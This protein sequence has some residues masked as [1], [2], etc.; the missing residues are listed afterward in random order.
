MHD[1]EWIFRCNHVP[2]SIIR[3]TRPGDETGCRM[4]SGHD[5]P[6]LV[7]AGNPS[8]IVSAGQYSKFFFFQTSDD[9]DEKD[10]VP[11]EERC[12]VVADPDPVSRYN[13]RAVPDLCNIMP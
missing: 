1:P 4:I 3:V 11:D 6:V 8:Q 9:L 10:I 12:P 5:I 13:L 7:Y 2:S